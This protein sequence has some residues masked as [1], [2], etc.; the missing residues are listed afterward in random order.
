MWN[1]VLISQLPFNNHI[2]SFT[3]FLF[4][5]KFLWYSSYKTWAKPTKTYYSIYSIYW[6]LSIKAQHDC[7]TPCHIS[8]PDRMIPCIWGNTS[9]IGEKR[10]MI[11]F[12][13][14]SCFS[15]SL[16]NKIRLCPN[17]WRIS[18]VKCIYLEVNTFYKILVFFQNW[19][20]LVFL[21]TC[22]HITK[23]KGLT[24]HVTA[25]EMITWQVL[26][27]KESPLFDHRIVLIFLVMRFLNQAETDH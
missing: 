24:Q 7:S 15:F 16:C 2:K 14:L 11:F 19:C 17:F 13:M 27:C 25:K 12:S 4:N 3:F 8:W 21:Y 22:L 9:H 10:N 23:I 1:N 26:A 20:L 18:Y 6:V 5:K